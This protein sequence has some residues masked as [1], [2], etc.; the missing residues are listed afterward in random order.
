MCTVFDESLIY[1]LS[2][3][4]PLV[5]PCNDWPLGLCDSRS[6]DFSEDAVPSDVV[7]DDFVTENGS[8]INRPS[9]LWYYLPDHEISEAMIFKSADNHEGGPRKI[10][11]GESS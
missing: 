7:F 6:V 11:P 3:W 5:G 2:T 1:V 9:H 8:F 4:K 10:S